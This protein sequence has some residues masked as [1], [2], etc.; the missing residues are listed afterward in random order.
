M[1]AVDRLIKAALA[2]DGYL[3]KGTSAQ[4]DS[5]TANAGY[6]NFTKYGRDYDRLMKSR[7]NGQPW[8]AIFASMMFVRCFGVDT[9]KQMIGGNL[10]ASCNTWINAL[11]SS[12]LWREKTMIAKP[13][14]VIFFSDA[15]GTAVHVG[16]VTAAG[17]RIETVEGNTSSAPGVDANGGAVR[18]K[19]YAHNYAR[20]YGYGRPRYELVKGGDDM[21]GEEIYKAL[22]EFFEKQSLP[23]WAKEEF[24]DAVKMGITDGSN[25][26]QLIPRYQAAIMVKRAKG[27]KEVG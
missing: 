2:E 24:T 27:K 1:I 5:K 17:G 11:K 25:P 21:T 6:N 13:G 4:L 23:E 12:G 9:A 10:F 3:E 16:I 20:I 18:T 8:C 19:S 7:L 14:D 22:T 26:M 15:K